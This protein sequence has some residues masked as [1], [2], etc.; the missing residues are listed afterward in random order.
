[1]NKVTG[2]VAHIGALTKVS[3][4]FQ[5]Q[6]FVIKT[7]DKFPQMIQFQAVNDKVTLVGNLEIGNLV[8]VN[9]NLQG[10]EWKN[11]KGEVKY[12]NTLNAWSITL[13]G[14]LKNVKDIVNQPAD[15]LDI[16]PF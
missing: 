10:R 3:D 9:Y 12:F 4:K 1:M 8:E 13:I 11:P 6:E 16:L 7:D 15:D 5:K 2:T 14:N